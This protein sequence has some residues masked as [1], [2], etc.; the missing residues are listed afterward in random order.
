MDAN[1]PIAPQ[2]SALRRAFRLE[3]P[4]QGT[5]SGPSRPISQALSSTWNLLRCL[6]ISS[7][8]RFAAVPQTGSARHHLVT[9]VS[10]KKALMGLIQ[11]PCGTAAPGFRAASRAWSPSHH[12]SMFCGLPRRVG[13]TFRDLASDTDMRFV[14]SGDACRT[15]TRPK[16]KPAACSRVAVMIPL[17]K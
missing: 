10:I 11:L 5:I 3:K 8:N 9:A 2:M 14:R 4:V 15:H 16:C 1:G 6:G 7:V 13:P 17:K 12:V